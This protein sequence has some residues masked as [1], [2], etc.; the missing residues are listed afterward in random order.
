MATKT[1]TARETLAVLEAEQARIPEQLAAAA[2]LADLARVRALQARADALADDLWL[3]RI[4]VSQE[5]VAAL[6][7]QLAA[8]TDDD[9]AAAGAEA[10]A[11]RERMLAATSAW[12]AR[13]ASYTELLQTRRYLGMDLGT[14]KRRL[15]EVLAERRQHAAAPVVRSLP[16]AAR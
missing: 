9:V 10:Q 16:H 12:E 2:D 4:A 5:D 13:A 15:A 11:A 1:S 3:A 14:A 7:A 6:E 8:I